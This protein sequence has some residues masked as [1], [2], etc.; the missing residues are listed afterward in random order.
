MTEKSTAP[1]KG[2]DMVGISLMASA[3]TEA[4]VDYIREHSPDATIDFRDV[5]YK[6]ERPGRLEF[7]MHEISDYL[8]RDLDTSTFLVNMSSYYGRIVVSNGKVEIFSEI[9]PERFSD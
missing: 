3:E 2:R 6:I 1:G 9:V 5:F 8:G 7:D 4:A